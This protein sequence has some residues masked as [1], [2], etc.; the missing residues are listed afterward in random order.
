[1]TRSLDMLRAP[2]GTLA[3]LLAIACASGSGGSPSH[4][5]MSDVPGEVRV[6]PGTGVRYLDV[7]EGGGA[8]AERDRCVY[9]HYTLYR[10][11]GQ[12]VETSHDSVSGAPGEP[13]AFLLGSGRVIRG[14]DIGIAGMRVG[15]IRR[16]WVPE[17]LAY[18]AAGSPPRIPPHAALV[19][20]IQ[21]MATEP[22]HNGACSSWKSIR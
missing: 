10:N 9:A 21:L 6:I 8:T 22:A 4:S 17:D 20:D 2:L 16:L 1:M 13:A 18:G 14:W 19:F 12:F 11:N 15:G 3:G 7:Q 5:A